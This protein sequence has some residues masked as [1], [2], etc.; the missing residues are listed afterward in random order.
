MIP[1]GEHIF[2]KFARF[3]LASDGMQRV[4][5]PEG[6]NA[7]RG[8]GPTNVVRRRITEKEIILP[9][10]LFDCLN[11]L[12]ETRDEIST[13]AGRI[14]GRFSEFNWV[15]IRYINHRFNRRTLMGFH[16]VSNVGLVTPLRD[17]MNLVAKEYVA[18]QDPE[19]PGVLILSRFAGTVH[20][21]DDGALVVN[22]YDI[23]ETADAM[24][25]ALAMPLDERK[26]RWTGMMKTL[27]RNNI[28]AWREKFVAALQEAPYSV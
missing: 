7:E 27:R 10:F 8:F 2:K 21:L 16:R 20:E 26:A 18:A 9:Q 5:V 15:P 22:P 19:D 12:F 1:A 6:A 11:G 25:Q 17:G 13:G 14:N 23:E 24:K 4:N 3:L 28:T